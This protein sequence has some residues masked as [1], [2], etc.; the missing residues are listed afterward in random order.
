MKINRLDDDGTGTTFDIGDVNGE[1]ALRITPGGSSD[2][3]KLAYPVRG[4]ELGGW[5]L[6]GEVVLNVYLPPE[7][8]LNP[9]T[10]FLG[11]G[12]VTS[13]WTWVG[14]QFGIADG[15]NGWI[16]VTFPLVPAL[17]EAR[18]DRAY[19]MYVAFFHQEDN[20]A[21][22]PL[23]EPFYL[24]NIVLEMENAPDGPEIEALYQQEAE[25][26]LAMDDAALVDAVARKTFD[27]FWHEASPRTGLIRD[28]NTVNSSAS[29][30]SVGFGLAAIPVAIERGWITRDEGYERARVTLDTFVSG[31]VQ[32]E[33]GFFYH[34]VDVETGQRRC[35]SELSSIDTA[36][37]VAGALVAG[38]Y[39]EG[40]DVQR[41]ADT[42]YENVEWDWMAAG[43][44]VPRMGWFPE[45]GFLSASWDH[46]DESLILYVLA[47]GSPTHP[48][49]AS[50]WESWRRPVNLEGEYI[51]LPGEPLFVYQYPLAFADL[52][53]KEDAYANYWNNTVRACERNRQFTIDRSD[54]YQT[55]RD[56][57]WGLSAS[58]GPFG[59]R[60][61]GAAEG[62][63][64]GTIAPYASVACLPFTP[65]IA[66]EGMR[67]MLRVYGSR[68]WGKYGFVSAINAD[69]DWYSHEHIGID[70]GDILLMIA[71]WQD[72]AVWEWF[73][74]HPRVQFGLDAM[75]FIES[76]GD[77][78]IT[79][80]YL[81]R[82]RGQ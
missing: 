11:L 57:V 82:V 27:F 55:Y 40:T 23:T 81:A 12:D 3:T 7:N 69:E 13:G 16:K 35:N 76:T 50:A 44:T 73:M 71:N 52:R 37:L 34:F 18:E 42:L 48:I 80:A 65:E 25:A 45:N 70:Q 77:Y 30:A 8:A 62:N 78:A 60:A 58:D 15:T 74:S 63:H 67:A 47:L 66:L 29:I 10:F 39:F 33:H 72:G 31:G 46:F 51:Y 38:Q 22:P 68:V 41:L 61:F 2:E 21:K 43:A 24:G 4:D 20:G 9:N 17:R 36:L 64:N 56:G 75:G 79:P 5:A 53:D 19:V 14:G 26:L 49:P 28:R 6:H 54:R 1:P 59:Y 32:G